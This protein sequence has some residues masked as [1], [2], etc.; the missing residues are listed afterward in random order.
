MGIVPAYGRRIHAAVATND[1]GFTHPATFR[2]ARQWWS[3]AVEMKS[4]VTDITD[5]HA[6]VVFRAM[7]DFTL[8][9]RI[10]L[11]QWTCFEVIVD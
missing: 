2:D 8:L 5:E 7:T 6:G 11:I 3:D 9:V 10:E 1:T 4:F